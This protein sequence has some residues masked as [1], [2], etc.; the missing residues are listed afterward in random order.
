MPIITNNLQT[1]LDLVEVSSYVVERNALR[2][3]ASL[4]GVSNSVQM[5]DNKD[6]KNSEYGHF[7]RNDVFVTDINDIVCTGLCKSAKEKRR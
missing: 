5:Q 3:K 4:F 7:S 6:Q 2:K 1:H